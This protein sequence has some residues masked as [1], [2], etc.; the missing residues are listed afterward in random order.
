MKQGQSRENQPLV[1]EAGQAVGRRPL[2]NGP[3]HTRGMRCGCVALEQGQE[4]GQHST[5][6]HEEVLVILEGAGVVRLEGRND[7]PVHAGSIAYVPPHTTHNVV[8]AQAA[9]LRYVYIV[10]PAAG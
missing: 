6:G 8:N 3:P 10:A 9:R 5:K 4:V 1:L 7:L 2:L